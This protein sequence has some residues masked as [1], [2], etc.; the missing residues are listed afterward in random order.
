MNS[1]FKK[2]SCLVLAG[3]LTAACVS[4]KKKPA[5]TTPTKPTPT[6]TSPNYTLDEYS[7]A[8]V[9]VDGTEKLLEQYAETTTHED[10]A[11]E[12]NISSNIGNK[13]YLKFTIET[14]VDLVGFINYYNVEDPSQT[15]SEKFFIKANSTEFTTFLDAFRV[16]AQ[17]A[18]KKVITTISFQGVDDTKEGHFKFISLGI[19]DRTINTREE[20]RISNG[21]M[22]IGTS[23]FYGGCVTYLEKLDQD[24]YEYMDWDGNIVIDRYVD[25]DYD[26]M[27][28]V[29]DSVNLINIYDLGR[30]VQP[31]YYSAVESIHGYNP[32]YDPTKPETYYQGLGGGVKYN[33]IQCGDFG[34]H[35]PQIIDYVWKEDYLYVI[36]KAQEW[37]FYTN[38]QANGYIEA[39]YYFDEDTGAIMVDNVYTDFSCFIG[40]WDIQLNAQETPATYFTYPLNYF[41]CETKQGKIFDEKLAEQNGRNQAKTSL[42]STV[43]S[44][45][46]F[47][48]IS[49]KNMMYDWCAFV[50]VNEFGVGIYMPNADDYIA[51]RGRRSNNYYSEECNRK[52]HEGFFSFAED[53]ITPSYA[54][55]NYNYINPSIKRKMVDFVPLEYTYALYVGDIA[56]MKTVFD[57]LESQNIN[58]HLL[59]TTTGWPTK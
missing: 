14:D 41:Y 22:V 11:V 18:Y 55:M 28:V 27:Q 45:D 9:F 10:G 19:S 1:I 12:Y 36:M 59:D 43:S 39:T 24:V 32:D 37:F 23:P 42:K 20:W 30:E 16:G 51:S 49:R 38:I 33:P 7:F 58:A 21:D 2:A 57:G 52:Y 3:M 54:A 5:A 50:N 4:C 15:N 13:N 47:Y 44:A 17:G 6:V 8:T 35:T 29:S 53:A 46:Y 48:A 26:A 40:E 25:P 31:S 34:G 56:E